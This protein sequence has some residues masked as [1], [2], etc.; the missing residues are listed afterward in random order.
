MQMCVA[1]KETPPRVCKMMYVT[2]TTMHLQLSDRVKRGICWKTEDD[3][4]VT[5]AVEP[6]WGVNS[7]WTHNHKVCLWSGNPLWALSSILFMTDKCFP[8][9]RHHQE[10]IMI[11]IR[12]RIMI[13]I[14][15]YIAAAKFRE[16]VYT[17][18]SKDHF[19]KNQ[20]FENIFFLPFPGAFQMQIGQYI[21]YYICVVVTELH[22]IGLLIFVLIKTGS[23]FNLLYA[24][25]R[26]MQG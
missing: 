14:K 6:P 21:T 5:W 18:V 9:L 26:H 24:H 23:S 1:A 4:G 13:W 3:L 22:L 20:N 7:A 17:W 16:V 8:L 19:H 15:R 25:L 12:I 10:T 11:C 2:V